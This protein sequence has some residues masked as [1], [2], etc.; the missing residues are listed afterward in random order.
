MQSRYDP[1]NE[2]LYSFWSFDSQK[3]GAFLRTLSASHF[4]SSKMSS[5]KNSTM[6][7]I[8]LGPTLTW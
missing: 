1:E 3:R 4:S 2:R 7:S 6:G 8:Q 5:L